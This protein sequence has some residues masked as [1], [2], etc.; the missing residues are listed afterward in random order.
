MTSKCISS[1]YSIQQGGVSGLEWPAI[2][3]DKRLF[4]ESFHR[5]AFLITCYDVTTTAIQQLRSEEGNDF[6]DWRKSVFPFSLAYRT[7]YRPLKYER[8]QF[9]SELSAPH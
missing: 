8:Q 4:E 3:T 5:C 1:W 6:I 7:D 2:N 9:W